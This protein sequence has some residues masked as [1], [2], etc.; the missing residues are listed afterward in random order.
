[1]EQRDSA[2]QNWVDASRR[3]LKDKDPYVRKTAA[4]C[5]VKLHEISP[6]L[7]ADQG[8]IESLEFLL[9][10]ANPTV[11][12]NAVAALQEIGS[13]TNSKVLKLTPASVSK[14]LTVL[15]E[16]SEWGQIYILDA[17]ATYLPSKVEEAEMMVDRVKPRL[18]HANSAVVL[19]SVKVMV[20]C[21]DQ[22]DDNAK[23][24]SICKALGP[25]LVTLMSGEAENQFVA[26]RNIQLI[27]QK[28]PSVLL[29]EV[30]VFFCRY[31]DPIYVKM[32]KL[33]VLVMLTSEHTVDQTLAEFKEYATEID[34]EFVCKAVRC[35]GRTAIKLEAATERCVKVLVYLIETKVNYLVQGWCLCWVQLAAFAAPVCPTFAAPQS[36]LQ[37]ACLIPLFRATMLPPALIYVASFCVTTLSMVRCHAEAIIVIRDIFR[38]YPNKYEDIITTLCANLDTLDNAEAKAAMVWIIGEYA[39]RIDNAAELLESFLEGFADEQ[40]AVQL[41]LLTATVKLFLK[42]PQVAQDMVKQVLA[43]VTQH[44]DSPDLRDR[45][46]MYWRLLSCDPEAAKAI[47]CGPKPTIEDDTKAIDRSLLD[48]L[49]DNLSNLASV[50]HKRPSAFVDR[51]KAVLETDDYDEAEE[52]DQADPDQPAGAET[53]AHPPVTDLLS[54]D[55]PTKPQGDNGTVG[56]DASQ[57]ALQDMLGGPRTSHIGPSAPRSQAQAGEGDLLSDLLG[58]SSVPSGVQELALLLSPDRAAGLCLRGGMAEQAGQAVYE[59][60][61][62]NTAATAIGTFNMML[63][64]NVY[65]L[66]VMCVD[67]PAVPAGGEQRVT[68]RMSSD[69]SRIQVAP[70]APT[71]GGSIAQVAIKTNAG[72]FYYTDTIPLAAVTV[73][74]EVAQ[75]DWLSQWSQMAV[76]SSQA[77]VIHLKGFAMHDADAVEAALKDRRFHIVARRPGNAGATAFYMSCRTGLFCGCRVLRSSLPCSAR[78]PSSLAQLSPSVFS[79]PCV[80]RGV[81]RFCHSR[82]WRPCWPVSSR[83]MCAAACLTIA[84]VCSGATDDSVGAASA[85]HGGAG[86]C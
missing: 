35:I 1:M 75:N 18:Q 33:D 17:L 31:N 29:G 63:N 20:K 24:A 60:H 46:Y 15:N 72:V 78:V 83:G 82:V 55:E 69:A 41:Q 34:H 37:Q 9:D 44:T 76:P 49:V 66:Q 39:D 28:R 86:D 26:L 8:F 36:P 21:L 47:V 54:L 32:E 79:A 62:S 25:P 52:T 43:Q 73:A 45:G 6:D 50:Y 16:A 51:K 40:H 77:A 10:D 5:V 56:M 23:I 27:C 4:I 70:P 58:S 11:V 3:A 67:V 30:K 61:L 65:G 42:R 19:S 38:K 7:V 64:K 2:R 53:R 71:A 81:S 22:L 57:D 48:E 59:L 84:C 80:N 68:L 12:T 74:H 14:L 13:R 85:A